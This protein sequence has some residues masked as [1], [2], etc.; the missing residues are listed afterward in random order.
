MFHDQFLGSIHY[1]SCSMCTIRYIGAI[2]TICCNEYTIKTNIQRIKNPFR[3]YPTGAGNR[4]D[5]HRGGVV[6]VST[7]GKVYTRIRNGIGGKGQY[8]GCFTAA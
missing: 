7:A 2:C 6:H 5:D 3:L 8:P 1:L 4:Y